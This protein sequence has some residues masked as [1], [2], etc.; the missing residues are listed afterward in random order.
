[1]KIE[2]FSSNGIQWRYALVG[3]RFC[4]GGEPSGLHYSVS[5]RVFGYWLAVRSCWAAHPIKAW[6]GG[7]Y[8]QWG[9]F[10]AWNLR[11]VKGGAR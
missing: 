5:V 7:V 10:Q 4:I 11:G 9:C 3:R 2:R 1:M 6:A 8:W